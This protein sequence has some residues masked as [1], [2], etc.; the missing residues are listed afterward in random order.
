M[1]PAK[2][3]LVAFEYSSMNGSWQF[4]YSARVK[5]YQVNRKRKKIENA[6]PNQTLI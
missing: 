2:F 1:K 6:C 5:I 3:Q 4:F